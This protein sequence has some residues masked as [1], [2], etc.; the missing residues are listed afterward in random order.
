MTSLGAS[1]WDSAMRERV[2]TL[3]WSLAKQLL[4]IGNTAIIEWGTWARAERD[5]L[6]HQAHDFGAAV[7]LIYL[8]VPDD[9][10][11]RRIQERDMEQPPIQRSN[12]AGWR[13]HFEAPDEQELG[14]YNASPPSP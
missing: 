4:L 10:L 6:R 1:V 13:Y 11:W 12:I 3:Q 9:E 5:A 14:L 2:E 7:E 8:D